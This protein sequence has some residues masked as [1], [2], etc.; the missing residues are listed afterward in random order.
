MEQPETDIAQDSPVSVRLP[1]GG[2]LLTSRKYAERFVALMVLIFFLGGVALFAAFH[3]VLTQPLPDT[4][5][6]MYAALR[7]LP[8]FIGPVLIFTMLVYVLV[9]SAAV[10]VLCGYTFH[11]IAGPLYRME[12]AVE[13]FESGFF[14][15]PV[16]LRDGD[17]LVGLAEAYNGFVA[18][19]RED[20]KACLDAME[21]S[22][23]LC[24][25]D[26]S[27]CRSE[28]EEALSRLSSVLSRYN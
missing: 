19:L 22:E 17:Q 9:M 3:V 7:N 26:A 25:L 1:P 12:L 10:A 21:H 28:R 15:R 4:Y 16:F 5:A 11:R 6:E 24:L 13:N 18:R 20:R 14:I 27:T 23:R 8:G 2:G